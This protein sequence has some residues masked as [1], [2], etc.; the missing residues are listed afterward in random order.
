MGVGKEEPAGR[1]WVEKGA[2][3]AWA[4]GLATQARGAAA[5]TPRGSFWSPQSPLLTSLARGPGGNQ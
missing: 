5:T 3:L 2:G 1:I 4:G